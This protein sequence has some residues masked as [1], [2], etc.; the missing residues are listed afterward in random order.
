MRIHYLTDD[1]ARLYAMEIGRADTLPK[2]LT[3]LRRYGSTAD[4]ALHR[5]SGMDEPAF[6]RWREGLAK[7]R[8]REYAGDEW[9][10]E[11]GAILL[12]AKMVQASIVADEFKVPW[13]TAW[14]Q[15]AK[16]GWPSHV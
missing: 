13:G 4:D 14:I 3:V 7:E 8:A 9:A 16:A 15:L 5:A 12:P 6:E 1:P 11:F 10:T 2:L